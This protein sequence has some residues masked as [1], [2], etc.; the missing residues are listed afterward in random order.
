MKRR[1]AYTLELHPAFR[2]ELLAWREVQQRIAAS[3]PAIAE[4]LANPE[5]AFLLLS[6]NGRQLTHSTIAKQV[7]WRARRAG[8][9]VQDGDRFQK[10]NVSA[11]S[12]HVM[13]RSWATTSLN[14]G[15]PLD[16]IKTV[17]NHTDISTTI[18][19]YAFTSDERRRDAI[20]GFSLGAN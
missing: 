14:D 15:Q 2:D 1:K 5:T 7:K 19:H 13:R 16:T 8:I 9:R 11:L 3:N 12:P 17:L 6:R 18:R 4:A 10:E 20:L